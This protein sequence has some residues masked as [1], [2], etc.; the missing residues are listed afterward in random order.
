MKIL[1]TLIMLLLASQ[2]LALDRLPYNHPG[3]VVDLGV[4]LW[5]WPAPMD[6]DG[7]GDYDLIVSCPDKPS[8]GIYLFENTTGDTAKHPLP[9]FKAGR[10][11][12]PTVKYLM[13]SYVEGTVRFTSPGVEYPE[14]LTKG[15]STSVKIP[16]D[17]KFHRPTGR[18]TQGPKLRHH[19]WR[20]TDYDGDGALDL[21]VAVEDWSDYGWDNAYDAEGQWQNGPLHGWIYLAKNIGMTAAPVYDTPRY[22]RIGADKLE[23]YGC[24]SPNLML[25]AISI[26]SV[27]SSSMASPTSR[28]PAPALGHPMRLGSG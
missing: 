15:I 28:T 25:M 13:P 23:T 18:Q 19:Q 12:G 16:L 22:L 24:P 7:D 9:V 27:A 8:N 11:L 1:G 14:L 2:A 21:I 4:G 20:Y 6:V 26:C 3:L 17:P 10:L 5:A